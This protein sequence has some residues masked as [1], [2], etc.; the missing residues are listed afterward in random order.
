MLANTDGIETHHVYVTLTEICYRIG[1]LLSLTLTSQPSA[2][3]HVINEIP[4]YK[5][6]IMETVIGYMIKSL[7]L[8]SRSWLLETPIML[9]RSRLEIS[10]CWS[11]QNKQIGLPHVL[12]QVR[13][14][15]ARAH[16]RRLAAQNG[17]VFQLNWL[18]DSMWEAIKM[19][20]QH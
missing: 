8:R 19:M 13:Y 1:A 7:S 3:R 6:K 2:T 9:Q 17:T 15:V 14:Q 20:K 16:E 10:V 4:T 18:Q 5:L 12:R 11:K